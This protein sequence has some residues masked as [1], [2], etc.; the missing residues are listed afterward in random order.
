MR[1]IPACAVTGQAAGTA[2]ALTPEKGRTALPTLQEALRR[3][4]VK[5]SL[6]EV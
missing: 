4:G 2:A 5:L 6:S 1:V 3:D